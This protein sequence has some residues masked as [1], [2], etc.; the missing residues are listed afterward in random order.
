MISIA[1]AEM[2]I[3]YN[4]LFKPMRWQQ[5]LQSRYICLRLLLYAV[6]YFMLVIVSVFYM[7][8]SIV[9]C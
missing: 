2:P 7:P 5:R 3:I 8:L 4:L 1:Y 6:F 9:L